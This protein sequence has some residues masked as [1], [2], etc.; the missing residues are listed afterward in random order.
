MGDEFERSLGEVCGRL[1]VA[2]A[3]LV[4][5]IVPAL[6]KG[7]WVGHGIRSAEHWVVWK[8][9]VSPARAA[10]LVQ[11][12]RRA[13]SLPATMET[14]GN[15]LLTA[16]QVAA[17]AAFAPDD[18]DEKVCAFA[19]SATVSQLRSVLREYRFP[20]PVRPIEEDSLS[21]ADANEPDSASNVASD[22]PTRSGPQEPEEQPDR[23]Y[24]RFDDVGRFHLHSDLSTLVGM[25]VEAA[26]QEARD[27]VYRGGDHRQTS[28]CWASHHRHH[29]GTFRVSGSA[30]EPE[31]LI[32]Q[33]PDGTVIRPGP[34][35][36]PVTPSGPL[37]GPPPGTHFQHPT[38]ERLQKRMVDF[39]STVAA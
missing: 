35:P 14:F 24:T 23:V 25:E 7:I 37:R 39:S 21:N 27:A 6:E 29:D 8:T 15:G 34:G 32:F 22:E 26:L 33:R 13:G 2:H 18:A 3:D 12:A 20:K 31:G 30:D 38:G 28:Q 16:D 17:I 36:E 4:S 5:L 1:D 19:R 9:G 11:I 10:E